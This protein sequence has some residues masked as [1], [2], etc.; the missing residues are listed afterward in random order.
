MQRRT[1]Q[2]EPCSIEAA[3]QNSVQVQL[4]LTKVEED[5]FGLDGGEELDDEGDGDIDEEQHHHHPL[6]LSQQPQPEERTACIS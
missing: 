1:G 5:E 6:Y 4:K 2:S 3:N